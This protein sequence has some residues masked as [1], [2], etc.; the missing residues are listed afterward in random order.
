MDCLRTGNDFDTSVERALSEIDPKWR[1]YPGL[2]VV[3]T[4]TPDLVDAKLMMIRDARE[5]KTPFL[6]ICFG[7]QLAAIEYARN[8]LNL[9]RA[10]SQ[11]IDPLTPDP[12]VEKMP[13]LRVG[14][15]RVKDRHES[16][17]HNYKISNAALMKMLPDWSVIYD[18]ENVAAEIRLKDYPFFVG[19]QFHP[20]Y[21]SSKDKPHPLLVEFLDVCRTA[22]THRA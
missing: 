18:E 13:T 21:G 19:V 8:V 10:H 17:W 2:L 22:D 20:E 1:D 14:I 3:G 4:H 15:R 11:E 7:A 16:Y 12:V 6:G 9:P 5:K